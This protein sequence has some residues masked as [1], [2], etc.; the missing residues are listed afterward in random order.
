[1]HGSGNKRKKV[2]VVLFTLP[3]N[4]PPWESVLLI[5]AASGSMDLETL[6]SKGKMDAATQREEGTICLMFRLL[7]DCILML[8]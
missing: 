1:M 8:P 2:Q 4:D 7:R 6:V 5:L 3:P